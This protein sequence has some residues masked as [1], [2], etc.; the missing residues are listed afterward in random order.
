MPL[1]RNVVKLSFHLR[2]GSINSEIV[3]Y[4]RKGMLP[5]IKKFLRPHVRGNINLTPIHS[6]KP[7]ITLLPANLRSITVTVST[8]L[9]DTKKMPPGPGITWA[10]GHLS[11]IFAWTGQ[12]FMFWYLLSLYNKSKL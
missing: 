6:H 5:P 12:F 8:C 9:E 2:G 1:S 3:L 10:A 11:E 4:S 7:A